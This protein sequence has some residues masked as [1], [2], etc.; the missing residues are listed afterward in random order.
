[1]RQWIYPQILM[2]L[3]S[4]IEHWEARRRKGEHES[5]DVTVIIAGARLAAYREVR[6]WI[7]P[8]TDQG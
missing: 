2:G 5:D 4:K 6:R 8:W 1:M 3:D 7:E